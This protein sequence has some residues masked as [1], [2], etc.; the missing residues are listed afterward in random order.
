MIRLDDVTKVYPAGARPALDTVSMEIE[1]GEFVFL[2]G[3]SGSGKTTMLR[4]LLR[5]E[6]CRLR[7]SSTSTGAT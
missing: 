6:I 5:E 1:K 3:Q 4:L 2:I 7:A